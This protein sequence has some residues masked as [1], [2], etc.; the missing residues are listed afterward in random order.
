MHDSKTCP[1]LLICNKIFCPYIYSKNLE[2][3]ALQSS[4]NIE[5]LLCC[6]WNMMDAR[7]YTWHSLLTVIM[8]GILVEQLFIAMMTSL[9]LTQ[10]LRSFYVIVYKK[11]LLWLSYTNENILYYIVNCHVYLIYLLLFHYFNSKTVLIC[12]KCGFCCYGQ[13]FHMNNFI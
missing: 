6:D 8:C 13:N 4:K 5:Q 12:L 7:K 11:Y 10:V 1:I 2:I 3:N 9:H